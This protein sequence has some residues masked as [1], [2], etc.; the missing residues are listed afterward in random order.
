[1]GNIK[2]S[3]TCLTIDANDAYVYAGTK[4]GD[5]LEVDLNTANFKRVAPCNMLFS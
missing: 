4:T 3:Y 2:R 1:M 5:I